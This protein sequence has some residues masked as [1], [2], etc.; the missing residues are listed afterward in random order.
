MDTIELLNGEIFKHDEILEL[1]KDDEFYYGYL[2]KAALSS[3]TIKLL[4]D[5]PKKYKYVTE[6]GSQESNALDA[7]WLFHTAILEPDVFEK[8]IFVD[9]QSK[10][11][12]AYKLA[13]EEHGKVYT[14]KQ[15]ND[16]ERLADAFLRNEHALQLIT[17]CEFE[18]PAIGMVQ[19]YPFRGKADVLGKGLVDLKTTSD[20]KAF[21]YS[22]RKYG[23]DVQVYLYTEL[24]NKP[25]Q[26]FKFAAIDKGSLDIGIY[27]V[28]EEFY[29]QGKAKVTKAL[30]VFE[31]FF[32]NGADIDSY[33]IKGTL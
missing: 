6:Y 26:E 2:G 27:D 9:V 7:G 17:D 22:A 5:S 30:E 25:Y 8:Q 1:M 18:V 23:Y 31:T 14:M 16:A 21:P 32:I 12:K 15:K 13:K 33:C 28:S 19:G 4:L 24:F 3:S 11:T 29:L 20:L 10:N